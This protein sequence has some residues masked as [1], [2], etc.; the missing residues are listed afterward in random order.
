[1]VQGRRDKVGS[2]AAVTVSAI[3]RATDLPCR[4]NVSAN[5]VLLQTTAGRDALEPP[6]GIEWGWF[7]GLLN[8]KCLSSEKDELKATW[9]VKKI[10]GL[11]S[12][13]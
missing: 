5:H 3:G 6:T 13:L 4:Q 2:D 8:P 12:M 7:G 9:G 11:L 1:M 10:W